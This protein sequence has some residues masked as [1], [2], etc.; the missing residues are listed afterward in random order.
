MD[1]IFS[2]ITSAA[3]TASTVNSALA[4]ANSVIGGIQSVSGTKTDLTQKGERLFTVRPRYATA[5]IENNYNN[6]G[7]A[8][9]ADRGTISS[10]RLLTGDDPKTLLTRINSGIKG[11]DRRVLANAITNLTN[12]NGAGFQDFLLTDVQV[13]YNEKVQVT[14]LF[15]DANVAYYF[16]QSPV[17]YNVSGLLFDSLDNNWFVQ[18]METYAEI[19]RG[20][21]LAANY[22]LIQLD[23]PNVTIIGSIMNL[24]YSQNAARDTDIPFSMQ[25][26]A[27]TI[28][29]RSY[30]V[31]GYTENKGALT[32]D[33]TKVS[34][35]TGF[36]ALSGIN[37][38]KDKFS[39]A[40]S[41]VFGGSNSAD[42]FQNSIFSPIYGV[43][44]SITKTVKDS[45]GAAISFSSQVTNVL[46]GISSD[47]VAFTSAIQ[48]AENNLNSLI[49]QPLNT[50][51]Q[52]QATI[53]TLKNTAG[54]ITSIPQTVTSILQKMTGS[55]SVLTG[56]AYLSSGVN[57][58]NK[59]A[60]LSA[61]TGNTSAGATLTSGGAS[62]TSSAVLS[63]GT[64]NSL[65][66]KAVL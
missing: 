42:S 4:S 18:F 43:V 49:Q 17:V 47:A 36:S 38:L 53:Q 20:S 5:I 6:S 64:P 3:S 63:S 15:G 60:L 37:A 9:V 62:S 23:L 12:T 32:I 61:G 35:L 46:R 55:G 2:L 30:D 22:Q 50:L 57:G 14:E 52:L 41:S 48:L 34:S 24:G 44:T 8:Y 28:S 56:A 11:T 27:K 21:R 54:V 10:L 25:I 26:L 16:G 1:G 58:G 19:I 29:H 45:T 39:S 33:F 7:S 13:T 65:V 59:S 40:V 51:K 31:A 66:K